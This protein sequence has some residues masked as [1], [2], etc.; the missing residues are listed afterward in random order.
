MVSIIYNPKGMLKICEYAGR[1]CWQS[2]DNKKTNA[3]EFIKNLVN[4]G[5]ESVIEHGFIIIKAPKSEYSAGTI[6]RGI[7]N[8]E[9]N[10]NASDVHASLVESVKDWFIGVNIRGLK[11]I[12]R[13]TSENNALVKDIK[14]VIIPQLPSAF[15][16][17]FINEGIIEKYTNVVGID[18]P[19]GVGNI[20]DMYGIL[21]NLNDLE[22]D[23]EKLLNDE[24]GLTIDKLTKL[25]PITMRWKAPISINEQFL[26]HRGPTSKQSLRYTDGSHLNY[27]VPND[28]KNAKFKIAKHILNEKTPQSDPEILEF[29]YH[30]F[31]DA[32]GMIYEQGNK[33]YG[34]K[35][36][37]C[38]F[39]LP[40]AVE[41]EVV[42]TK[43]INQW[44]HTMDLRLEPHTQL[45]SR[46]IISWICLTLTDGGYPILSQIFNQMKER[47]DFTTLYELNN[48]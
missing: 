25:I 28:L 47:I 3:D 26:R 45:H 37:D 27:H 23:I 16:F 13:N 20:N 2:H 43:P 15:F 33:I 36:E 29:S 17:D 10:I 22:N 11:N 7:C 1:T 30:D 6:L 5:H 8:V 41:T 38:R 12:L 44:L 46:N 9:D 19:Y 24:I 34:A 35:K 39:A 21:T 18:E 40:I 42:F 32:A 4:I 14:T 31:M 48:R